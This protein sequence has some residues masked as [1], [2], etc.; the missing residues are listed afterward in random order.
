MLTFFKHPVFG[1]EG[2][3]VS[4]EIEQSTHF[5][6]TLFVFTFVIRHLRISLFSQ[7]AKMMLTAL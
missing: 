3:V 7:E 4:T 1:G 2:E 5:S 6:L